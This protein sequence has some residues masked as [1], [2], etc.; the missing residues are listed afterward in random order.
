MIAGHQYDNELVIFIMKDTAVETVKQLK[1][2]MEK[3]DEQ[4]K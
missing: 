4:E 3:L 1:I 2:A